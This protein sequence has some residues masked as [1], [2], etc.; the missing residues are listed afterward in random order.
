MALKLLSAA[1]PPVTAAEIKRHV[2]AADFNDDDD[3]L[4]ALVAVAQAHIDGADGWLGRAV[5][6]QQWELRLDRFPCA[7]A[8]GRD[9]VWHPHRDRVYI[10]LPPLQSVD[11]VKYVDINGTV[12]SITDFREFGV[13]STTGCGFVLPAFNT[14]WPETRC[15]PEAVRITFTAGYEAVPVEVKHAIM[16]MVGTWYESREDAAEIKLSEMPRGVDA[17]LIPLRFW[18]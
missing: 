13:G 3:Y 7:A 17:L 4:T 2:R 18:G 6:E 5:G 14:N 8:V 12:Q 9:L 15:E 10:P 1:S 11:T 16:L